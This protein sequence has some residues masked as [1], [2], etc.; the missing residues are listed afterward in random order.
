MTHPRPDD[1]GSRAELLREVLTGGPSA[2]GPKVLDDLT[3]TI[4]RA[5]LTPNGEVPGSTAVWV[6]RLRQ[7]AT[8]KLNVWG[9][10]ALVDDARLLISELVTNGFKHGSASHI[11]FCLVIGVDAVVMQVDDGSPVRPEVRAAGPESVH[12]RGLVLVSALAAAW[13]VSDDGTRTWCALGTPTTD[14]AG[15]TA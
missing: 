5:D 3:L 1:T 12:G 15:R 7:I 11:V 8:A 4:E 13:G 9:M 14:V 2:A 6:G 10:S